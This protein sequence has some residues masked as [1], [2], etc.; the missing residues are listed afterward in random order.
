MF[1]PQI[2]LHVP[3][4][5]MC[6]RWWWM[7]QLPSIGSGVR[8]VSAVWR[9]VL[10]S[11]PFLREI[12]VALPATP[13]DWFT[14]GPSSRMGRL[15]GWGDP[16]VT[17]PGSGTQ[18]WL[19]CPLISLALA[20]AERAHGVPLYSTGLRQPVPPD[21]ER[22]WLS[23]AQD[24]IDSLIAHFRTLSPSLRLL[25]NRRDQT[26]GQGTVHG[27]AGGLCPPA[28]FNN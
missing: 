25:L 7:L 10:L 28:H 5:R 14:Q 11:H 17:A 26:R 15:F 2:H 18:S 16:S 19:L 9:L 12:P 24:I 3:S 20:G 1:H 6:P 21:Q 23:T 13:R 27:F 4:V 22:F 8:D